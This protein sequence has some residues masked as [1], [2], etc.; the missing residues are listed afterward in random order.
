MRVLRLTQLLLAS[1]PVVDCSRPAAP[2]QVAWVSYDEG[3]RLAKQEHR[4]VC[5]IFFT[6]WCPHCANFAKVL[7]DPRVIEQAQKLVMVRVDADQNKE[8]SSRYA[9]DG[10]Y[11][12]RT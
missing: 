5:L 7:E 9:L 3:L 1:M 6:R 10:E 8:L 2:T 12:P 4:P 11:I